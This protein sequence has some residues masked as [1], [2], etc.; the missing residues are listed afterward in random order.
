M[1]STSTWKRAS[2]AC[3]TTRP[4]TALAWTTRTCALGWSWSTLA[5]SSKTA[6]FRSSRRRSPVA[7]KSKAS[8]CPAAR[9][10]ALSVAHAHPAH[11]TAL[12]AC[13]VVGVWRGFAAPVVAQK[14]DDFVIIMHVCAALLGVQYIDEREARRV[15]APLVGGDGTDD[16]LGQPRLH[17]QRFGAVEPAMRHAAFHRRPA[18]IGVKIDLDQLQKDLIGQRV[19]A[20]GEQ[21]GH[22]K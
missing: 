13:L 2:S 22:P 4:S 11:R 10:A 20:H 5:K 9:A 7:E 16:I 17:R 15:D 14:T 8:A 19:R 3:A 12:G 1:S 6:T 21:K 18:V